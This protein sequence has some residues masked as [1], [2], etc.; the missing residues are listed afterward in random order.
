MLRF[1]K[2]YFVPACV[3]IAFFVA[4]LVVMRQLMPTQEGIGIVAALVGTAMFGSFARKKM[5]EDITRG[6]R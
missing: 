6:Y 5:R 3:G 4:I 1:V 2:L